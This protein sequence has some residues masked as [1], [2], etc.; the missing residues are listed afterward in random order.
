[1]KQ[2]RFEA[3]HGDEWRRLEQLLEQLEQ[4]RTKPDPD[5]TQQFPQLYR[6]VCHYLALAQERRYSAYLIEHLND[7]A[8]RGHH[9]LYRFRSNWRMGLFRFLVADFPQAV[10]QEA[11]FILLAAAL[12]FGPALL[13]FGLT[14]LEPHLVFSLLDPV[15]VTRMEE[16][17]NPDQ[18]HLGR[19]RASDTDFM[20]FGYYIY[21]NISV[22]FRCFAGGLVFMVGALMAILFNGLMLGAVAGHLTNQGF[23]DTFFPF[24]I[25][26]GAFELT[27]IAIAGG[28]GLK[29]GYSILAPGRLS[30]LDALKQAAGGAVRIMYGV[31]LMLV[32][33]A[34][35]EAFW[36]S[37][38]NLAIAVKYGVGGLLWLLVIVYFLAAGR[39]ARADA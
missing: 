7:L 31:I 10:R 9:Q 18:Q 1:M 37:S 15:Q 22:A 8:L 25:G 35:I 23:T 39:T 29:L 6:Q 4:R 26:H 33:A 12:L 28:A 5:L 13:M 36:S 32:I 17:Y 30:R 38:G 3:S 24:V 20:M 19:E 14:L 34:F 21:N 11:G 27:A 2:E 16:M